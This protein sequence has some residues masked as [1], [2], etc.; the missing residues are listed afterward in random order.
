M[1][2][3]LLYSFG[4]SSGLNFDK[5]FATSTLEEYERAKVNQLPKYAYYTDLFAKGDYVFRGYKKEGKNGYGLQIYK[6]NDLIGDVPMKE[7]FK[8][9]GEANG[10]YYLLLPVDLD[11]ECFKILKFKL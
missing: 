6:N 11:N 9:I 5:L 8:F 2:G 7:S 1:N 3:K 4:Y 10:F